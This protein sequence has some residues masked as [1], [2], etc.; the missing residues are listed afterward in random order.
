MQTFSFSDSFAARRPTLAFNTLLL[1]TL[2]LLYPLA[3]SLLFS[4]VTGGLQQGAALLHPDRST[5]PL[6]RLVQSVGQLLMLAFPVI[7]LSAWHTG[8]RNPFSRDSLA[9]LGIQR[10]VDFGTVALA[11]GGIFLLQ[12]L[13]YTITALQDLYLWPSFGDAGKEVIRQRE[14]MELFL[15][16]LARVRS[17]PEFLQVAFVLA[18]TPAVCEEMLFRGY[19]QQNYS[20]SI[21]S[22]GAVL[23]TGLVFAFFHLSA[24]NLLPLALLGWY[25]GY[26]YSKT[27]NLAVPVAV[28]L[29]N[30]L[31]ALL[32][33]LFAE[34]SGSRMILR[35]DS[36]LDAPW[37]W[38]VVAV[39]LL[40]LVMVVRRFSALSISGHAVLE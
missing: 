10:G 15:K 11:L 18:L 32:F 1:I 35:I 21:S 40:L 12:P 22:G 38:L 13:L 29:I 19:I 7:C 17:L 36:L 3:G 2:M 20:H 16:E 34:G 9:F 24:A 4:M 31:A 26:I 5:I 28:H 8:T 6:L 23:L 25:I 27:G 14:T 30:N 37:W 39:S 33:L